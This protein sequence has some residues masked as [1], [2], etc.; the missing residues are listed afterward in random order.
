MTPSAVIEFHGELVDMTL[1][2]TRYTSLQVLGEGPLDLVYANGLTA[3]IDVQWEH[4]VMARFLE[5]L[6]PSAG[7]SCSTAAA[8]APPTRFHWMPSRR[9]RSGPTTSRRS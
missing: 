8:P 9:G 4:P 7:S 1:P 3:H 5:R 2:Q 6:A